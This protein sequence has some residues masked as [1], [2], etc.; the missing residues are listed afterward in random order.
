MTRCWNRL[1]L[2]STNYQLKIVLLGISPMIWRRVLVSSD[3]T[4][5]DLHH[6]VQLTMG[7]S[8]IHLHHFII[9]GQQY[10]ITQP[11]GT[12]FSTR[13]CE[14]K[15]S[16]FELRETEKFIYEY[17]FSICPLMGTW[18]YWWRYLLRVEAILAPDPNQTYPIC[19]GGKGVCP[20][21]NCG[22]PW[23]FM[24]ARDEFSVYDVLERFASMLRNQKLDMNREE[25][26]HLLTWLLV[27]Q[28]HFDRQK[29]N[30][31]LLQYA[32]RNRD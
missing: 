23:G 14:V 27:Y 5:E 31:H 8:D 19:T 24:K 21:E 28:N 26:S 16:F 2:S 10:G 9:H 30:Q 6:I 1:N 32:T 13:A 12:I 22:G 7:W 20:P 25:A 4:I 3:S 15:L 18:R 17:D 29:V 11:S